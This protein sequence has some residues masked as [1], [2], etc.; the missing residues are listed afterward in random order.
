MT[1]IIRFMERDPEA[2]A[3]I[4]MFAVLPVVFTV[5]FLLAALV[6]RLLKGFGF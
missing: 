6:D 1:T 4:I 2:A 5:L 3:G